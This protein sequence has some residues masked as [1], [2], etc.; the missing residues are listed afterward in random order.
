MKHHLLCFTLLLPTLLF[1]QVWQPAPDRTATETEWTI[2]WSA[3]APANAQLQ[4]PPPLMPAELTAWANLGGLHIRVVVED[5]AFK[6][7]PDPKTLFK[8]DCLYLEIDGLGDNPKTYGIGEDDLDLFFALTADGPYGKINA[9]GRQQLIGDL[10]A[11]LF[12]IEFDGQHFTYAVRLPWELLGT[13]PGMSP[14]I[15][16]AINVAHKPEQDPRDQRWGA[17]SDSRQK[18]RDLFPLALEAPSAP[19]IYLGQEDQQILLDP[20]GSL[21]FPISVLSAEDSR[22]AV[23]QGDDTLE[24]ALPAGELHT[25][26]VVTSGTGDL[27]IRLGEKERHVEIDS[28]ARQHEAILN[29]L[30]KSTGEDPISRMHINSLRALSINAMQRSL[31]M[32][33]SDLRR[34]KPEAQWAT[35]Y[36][37]QKLT[38]E[39]LPE[40]GF[41]LQAHLASARPLLLSFI[42][43]P[44]GSLQFAS[45]QL[46][47]D[48]DPEQSYPLV[49]YLHGA[50]PRMP[51]DFLLTTVDN[52]WQDTL[53]SQETTPEVTA[54]A[55]RQVILV[56]PYGRG[57]QGYRDFSGSDVWQS[58]RLTEKLTQVDP[59]RRYLSGFSMGCSGTFA[60]AADRPEYWAAIVAAAGF[61]PPSECWNSEHYPKLKGIPLLLWCGDADTRMYNGYKKLL[62]ILDANDLT[63]VKTHIAP[64]VIHTFPYLE[65]SRMLKAAFEYTKKTE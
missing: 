31:L 44:D 2:P 46:P 10:D 33:S 8:G 47:P 53:W 58:L 19:F 34:A 4:L 57:T 22:L 56:A 51:E 35:I 41:D 27:Q 61:H 13:A 14:Q 59:Q 20:N 1:A 12:S 23:Q 39:G 18:T 21:R 43:D 24:V 62:P 63:P 30:A 42:A 45:L 55:Q 36:K 9:H 29:R 64:G 48:Y 32:A 54:S 50:G 38:L 49:C 7:H 25:G 6:P 16:M 3:E 15:G 28:I 40:D 37:W 11:S 5:D 60:I 26:Y 65:Y 17:R 52:Y